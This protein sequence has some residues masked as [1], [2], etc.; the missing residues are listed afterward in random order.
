MDLK[1]AKILSFGDIGRAFLNEKLSE[2][3][4]VNN[5]PHYQ[6]PYKWTQENIKNLIEDWSN[7]QED[8]S[9][10]CG[11]TVAVINKSENNDITHLNIIDGQQRY[12]TLYLSTFISFLISIELVKASLSQID[13]SQNFKEYFDEMKALNQFVENK[14][15]NLSNNPSM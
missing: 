2:E 11:S 13:Y 8:S 12:T 6:R 1:G 5:I 3:K 14:M 7:N 9:Y 4:Y 10:F 15:E